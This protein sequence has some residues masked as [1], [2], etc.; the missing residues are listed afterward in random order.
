[1]N[2]YHYTHQLAIPSRVNKTRHTN[3]GF[4]LVELMVAIGVMVLVT[5]VV[6]IRQ[7]SFNSVVL[8]ENQAYELAF[9]IRGVQTQAVGAQNLSTSGG[10]SYRESLGV[11]V[12]A[13]D[14]QYDFVRESPDGE[15]FG[16]GGRLDRRFEITE[17]VAY[18]GSGGEVDFP[19]D[20]VAIMFT[21]PNF[22]AQ[23]FALNNDPLDSSVSAVRISIQSRED[24]TRTRDVVVTSTGQVTVRNPDPEDPCTTT[25]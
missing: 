25:P 19:G 23:F 16:A 21:R 18:N 6:I 12:E 15:L 9:D 14:Q 4:G 20:G 11:L 7:S 22:D 8:L 13:G 24:D 2:L 5:T 1:M 3:A 10:T 17:V